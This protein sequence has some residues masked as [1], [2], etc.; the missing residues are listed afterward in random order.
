ML[1]LR[2]D[3]GSSF[4]GTITIKNCVWK[5]IF[6]RDLKIIYAYNEGDHYFG[7]DCFLSEDIVID[8]LTVDDLHIDK[9]KTLCVFSDYDRD[10]KKGKPYEYILPKKITLKG[11]KSLSGKEIKIAISDEQFDGIKIERT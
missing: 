6:N 9:D 2:H 4:K 3:Y 1:T 11:L 7:Y 5:P 10:F 8:G